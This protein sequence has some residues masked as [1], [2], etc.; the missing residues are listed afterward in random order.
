MLLPVVQRA[1]PRD[2]LLDFGKKCATDAN[3]TFDD[4]RSSSSEGPEPT[5]PEGDRGTVNTFNKL[6]SFLKV[7]SREPRKP[8]CTSE[9]GLKAAAEGDS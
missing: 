5:T 1:M 9:F 3:A 7:E 2:I 4:Q 6:L 8:C